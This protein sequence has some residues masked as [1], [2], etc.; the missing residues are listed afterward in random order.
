MARVKV[1]W[2][3]ITLGDLESA[4]EYVKAERPSA[5][6]ALID[7]IEEAV[8]SLRQYP[9]LGRKGRVEGTRELVIAHTPF[10]IPYR[11]AEGIVEILAV[12]HGARR[13]PENL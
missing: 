7:R 4:Y 8:S 5:A 9:D 2:T 3:R 1:R 10:V 11:V 6:H 12:I 13:W